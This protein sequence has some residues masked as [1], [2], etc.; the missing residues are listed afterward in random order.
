[1][2]KNCAS[3]AFW[4]FSGFWARPGVTFA[5]KSRQEDESFLDVAELGLR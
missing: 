1:M 5:G 4:R 2:R 3:H